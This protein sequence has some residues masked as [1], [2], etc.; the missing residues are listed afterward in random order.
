MISDDKLESL[1]QEVADLPAETQDEF[2]QSLIEMRSQN[3]GI[4]SQE[5]EIA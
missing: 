3:L 4:N 5:H 1:I 2:F